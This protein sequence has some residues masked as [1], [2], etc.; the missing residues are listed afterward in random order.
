MA[1]AEG[2]AGLRICFLAGTLEHGGAER[3][4]F[5]MLQSLCQ[6]GTNVRVLSLDRGQFW[7]EPIRSLGVVVTWVGERRSRLARLVRIVKEVRSEM[8]D[9]VQ[10][11]HFFANAYAALAGILLGTKGVGAIRN[12][13]DVE[14]QSNGA[15]GGRLNLRLPRMIA[16]NSR[17]AIKQAIA[18]GVSS[19]RLYF[20]P[21][22]VDT[23]R[24][25]PADRSDERPLTLVAV[26]RVARQKR[27]DRFISALGRLRS[28]LKTEVRGWIV[29]P[30]G[31]EHLRA[32]LEAQGAKLG[33]Y[34]GCL[35]FLGGVSDMGR[36]YQEADICVLTSDF[37]G[38]PNVLLEAMA[39]GLPVV[40][41]QVGGV[42]EI[43]SKTGLA[44]WWSVKTW[45]AW[46]R[47]WLN[48]P[49]TARGGRKWAAGPGSTRKSITRL[50]GCPPTWAVSITWCFRRGP[51]RR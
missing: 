20:L 32:E 17:F 14:M 37:E 36:V 26:G 27:F 49:R 35:R 15:I 43:Y 4:L 45:T 30:T 5:Y 8:P 40:A 25:K 19:S 3:Q 46:W 10:S 18:R 9:L 39:A 23:G 38:T 42:P 47:R 44:L 11:Q 50:S 6:R 22:A 48:W 28:E 2:V 7:E 13:G 51:I 34:P 1:V 21:N 41:T 16:V 31:D 33:L 29:G 24:F 12:E